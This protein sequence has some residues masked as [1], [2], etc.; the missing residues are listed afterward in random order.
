VVE[1]A[2]TCY[3]E[4]SLTVDSHAASG[5][6][7]AS[8]ETP[9]RLAMKRLIVRFRHPEAKPMQSVTVNGQA[10]TSF[11]ARKEWVVIEKPLEPRY[12]IVTRY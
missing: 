12:V 9:K 5:S 6:L 10:W 4:L 3:G 2:P 7:T 11:D 1:R 8:I